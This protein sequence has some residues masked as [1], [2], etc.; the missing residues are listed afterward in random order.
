MLDVHRLLLLREVRLRGSM[1]AAA[2]ELSYSH[3]AI[4]Q[5]LALLER[6][7]GTALLQR[8]GRNVRLTPAGEDLVRS[9]EAILAAIE[10]AEADL[11]AFDERPRGVVRVAAFASISRSIMPAAL[12]ALADEHPGLDVRMRLASPEAAV[13]RLTSRQVDMVITDA[14]PGT[15]ALAADGVHLTAIGRDPIRGYLPDGV[16]GTD[17]E[18]L[19]QVT[20]V[21]EPATAASTQW[22]LRVC[23]EHGFEPKVSHE[24]TDLLFHL[25]MVEHG[26]AAAFL[27]DMVLRES[28]SSLTAS[29]LLPSNQHR[30]IHLLVREGS[31]TR[32]ALAAVRNAVVAAF[33]TAMRHSS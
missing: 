32:P 29:S 19:R 33:A 8:V 22:A 20:W 10:R 6:E 3:S 16:D 11:A 9:T 28:G 25:R 14:Y 21:M 7:V 23:R 5:Q 15:E 4:S 18:R 2:R 24:S 31:E 17:P 13:P 26:L 1:T 12:T 27:P 30:T